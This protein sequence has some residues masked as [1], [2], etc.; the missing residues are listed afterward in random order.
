[1]R[2]VWSTRVRRATHLREIAASHHSRFVSHKR[3]DFVGEFIGPCPSAAINSWDDM[4]GFWDAWDAWLCSWET[5]SQTT[6][7]T[8]RGRGREASSSCSATTSHPLGE[9]I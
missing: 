9:L 4:S 6:M 5:D 2:E 1:M 8:P 7:E 3:L